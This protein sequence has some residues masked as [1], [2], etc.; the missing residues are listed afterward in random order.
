M[1]CS[2]LKFPRAMLSVWT[3]NHAVKLCVPALKQTWVSECLHQKACL[4]LQ[5]TFFKG[6]TEFYR[7]R[8]V[9]Q[10]ATW[11]SMKR[12]WCR[13]IPVNGKTDGAFSINMSVW[14]NS[15]EGKVCSLICIH[16][17]LIHPLSLIYFS[18]IYMFFMQNL[19]LSAYC[20]SCSTPVSLNSALRWLVMEENI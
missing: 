11:K 7:K 6:L 3:I 17:T 18:H 10:W 15:W 19:A 13:N 5:V 8:L 16:S 1:Q 14:F 9:S 20:I 2:Y 4:S 12:R